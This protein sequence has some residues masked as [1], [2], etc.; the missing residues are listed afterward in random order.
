MGL[1]HSTRVMVP[2]LRQPAHTQM[3]CPERCTIFPP[4]RTGLRF[5]FSTQDTWKPT[6]FAHTWQHHTVPCVPW[7]WSLTSARGGAPFTWS[8]GFPRVSCPSYSP[9]RERGQVGKKG[10]HLQDFSLHP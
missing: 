1:A 3:S 2:R 4:R 7:S 9:G 8:L 6:P 5:T 10:V